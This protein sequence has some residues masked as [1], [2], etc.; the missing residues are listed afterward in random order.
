VDVAL[1]AHTHTR[2]DKP[3]KQGGALVVQSGSHGSFIT[4]LDLTIEDGKIVDYQHQLIEVS[5]SIEPDKE[6]D[7]LL[8]NAM[9][10]YRLILGEVVGQTRVPLD[11]GLNLEATMDNFLL[12]TLLQHTGAEIAFSNGYRYGAPIMPGP[13]L[14][15]DH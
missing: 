9:R 11:R 8:E 7:D 12:T 14:M 1:S 10:P 4:R 5:E 3:V 2:L 15:N 6:V 13:I